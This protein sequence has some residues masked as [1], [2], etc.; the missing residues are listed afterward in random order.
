[1]RNLVLFALLITLSA[2]AENLSLF[3]SNIQL[4]DGWTVTQREKGSNA[5]DLII[6]LTNAKEKIRIRIGVMTNKKPFEEAAADWKSSAEKTLVNNGLTLSDEH[7][8]IVSRGSKKLAILSF[9]LS[10]D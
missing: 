7:Y 10:K 6:L 4:P 8:Q 9:R 1:M 5:D 3:N 2:N